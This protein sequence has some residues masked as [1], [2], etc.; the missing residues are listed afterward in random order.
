MGNLTSPDG[1]TLF[2]T[3][4]TPEQRLYLTAKSGNNQKNNS[5]TFQTDAP[6][7][8]KQKTQRIILPKAMKIVGELF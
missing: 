6:R 7:I 8:K 2:T 5:Q 3:K 1:N 4:K